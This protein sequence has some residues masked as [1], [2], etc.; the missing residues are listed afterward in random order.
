[1]GLG[2]GVGVGEERGGLAAEI[3]FEDQ[4]GG[5]L[6]DDFAAGGAVCGGL[7]RVGVV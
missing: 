6:V 2:G 3:G 5:D 7:A 1:M 4:G